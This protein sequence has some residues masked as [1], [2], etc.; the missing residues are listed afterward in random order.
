M[1]T[2]SN[3]VFL[4]IGFVLII[5][6]IIA[7]VGIRHMYVR[8]SRL[9]YEHAKKIEEPSETYVHG[10]ESGHV[11][12]TFSSDMFESPSVDETRLF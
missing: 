3:E 4:E 10:G 9:W 1:A 7:S 6:I 11:D 8:W 5:G 2:L 12:N